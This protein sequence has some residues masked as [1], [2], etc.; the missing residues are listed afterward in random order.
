MCKQSS[1]QTKC[2][3]CA[4]NGVCSQC[5]DGFFLLDKRCAA[6]YPGCK[7][8]TGESAN[9]CTTCKDGFIFEYGRCFKCE[10]GSENTKCTSC[11]TLGICKNCV[12]GYFVSNGFCATCASNCKTCK[13]KSSIE[14]T[15]CN[16]GYILEQGECVL[17]GSANTKCKTCTDN[18]DC[19]KCV[20]EY[21]VEHNKCSRCH[22][23][24]K[25]CS[26]DLP[27]SCLNCIDNF[28]LEGGECIHCEM[29][30][31]IKTN[32]K[33]CPLKGECTQCADRF[34]LNSNRCLACHYPCKTCNSGLERGCLSC[35]DEYI[36]EDGK[37]VRC[38]SDSP[39]TKC[40]TCKLDGKCTQCV[41]EY[42][43]DAG[44]CSKCGDDCLKCSNKNTCLECKPK[45]ILNTNSKCVK[46]LEN[47]LQASSEDPDKCATCLNGYGL[48]DEKICVSLISNC[49]EINAFMPE[50]CKLC[51]EGFY[52]ITGICVK[53]PKECKT[54]AS[55]HTCLSCNNN[56]ILEQG[57]CA[58][59]STSFLETSCINCAVGDVCTACDAGYYVLNGKCSKC[60]KGCKSCG[61]STFNQCSSCM[62]GYLYDSAS[63][64]CSP[65]ISPCK[66]CKTTTSTCS[67]CADF[68]V[69]NSASNT[70]VKSDCQ[71][72][73]AAPFTL[74]SDF[75]CTS[76]NRKGLIK[77]SDTLCSDIQPPVFG[78]A[79]VQVDDSLRLT[80]NCYTANNIY[81]AYGI[82]N[83]ALLSLLEIQELINYPKNNQNE[84][85]RVG[86]RQ[87][88]ANEEQ[89]FLLNGIKYSGEIYQ[90]KAFCESNGGNASAITNFQTLNTTHSESLILELNATTAINSLQKRLIAQEIGY[91]LQSTKK[92]WVD[93]GSFIVPSRAVTGRFLQDESS[94]IA[95]FFILPE[96]TLNEKDAIVETHK[97]YLVK[98][99]DK[100]LNDL[101]N[102]LLEITLNNLNLFSYNTAA[103]TPYV[104]E[105]TRQIVATSKGIKI[106][107]S[108]S[109]LGSF[110][111]LYTKRNKLAVNETIAPIVSEI[112]L[113]KE[114]ANSGQ[115]YSAVMVNIKNLTEPVVLS[116]ENL[117]PN[118][119]YNIYY[120]G[121]NEG[122]PKVT[123]SI[124]HAIVRTSII[125]VIEAD[126]AGILGFV[127][128]VLIL[129]TIIN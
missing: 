91:I 117:T 11:P 83:S 65:C 9:Q 123:T 25:S 58:K 84:Y 30:V 27:A 8:C 87:N 63:K 94:S 12:E 1:T 43:V 54:C 109:T 50:E 7:T 32:C 71:V 62:D 111:V 24:C 106:S 110:A 90:F 16:A 4:S 52:L 127:W 53:C 61:D 51:N 126:S 86:K 105:E 99:K 76:C 66:T 22:K 95:R 60:Y 2:I 97:T 89:V 113:Q 120:Y 107:F 3:T 125:S 19:L 128:G 29:E 26:S 73:K 44:K 101:N 40:T 112:Q 124:Y 49:K 18:G 64:T 72:D 31:G 39:E 35:A 115:Q 48:T 78:G 38:A 88:V 14:C 116:I 80:V 96:Y 75:T 28:I 70:C 92:I 21:F 98:N 67:S 79:K 37:C 118:T 47:C 34:Y 122:F 46:N 15:S 119:T 41:D 100:F 17:C 33:S 57:R 59:C 45:S 20:D 82:G 74:L 6:C 55:H 102:R 69:F 5:Q 56:F 77:H 42:F 13:S 85:L 10:L 103:P 93:D 68:Y 23:G 129:L 104:N 121:E 36:L 114:L 81:F 108:Q